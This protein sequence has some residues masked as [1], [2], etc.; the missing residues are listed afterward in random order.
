MI[1]LAFSEAALTLDEAWN[2]AL[3]DEK[4][5]AEFWGEDAEAAER[6]A[7]RRRELEEA[8]MFLE[9]LGARGPLKP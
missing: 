1:A 9:L 4:Y 7:G 2:A 5:Q 8:S 3:V 6:L